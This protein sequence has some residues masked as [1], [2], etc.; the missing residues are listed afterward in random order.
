MRVTDIYIERDFAVENEA[1]AKV[2]G[3]VFGNP[4]PHTSDDK[5]ETIEH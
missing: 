3:Y 1:N 2:M 4:L 5:H